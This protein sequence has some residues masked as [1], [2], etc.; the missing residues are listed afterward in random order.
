M[1]MP[2]LAGWSYERRDPP[3]SRE[4]ELTAKFLVRKDWI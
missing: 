4:A 3:G 1:S 2:P